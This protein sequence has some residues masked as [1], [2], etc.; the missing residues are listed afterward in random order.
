MPDTYPTALELTVEE[1]AAARRRLYYASQRAEA[2][3]KESE[4]ADE[5]LAAAG[6]A[7]DRAESAEARLLEELGITPTVKDGWKDRV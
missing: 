3:T 1:T 6:A 2:A 4:L 7:L 5:E